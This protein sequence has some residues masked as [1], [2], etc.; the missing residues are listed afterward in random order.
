MKFAIV[1]GKDNSKAEELSKKIKDY[2]GSKDYE[3][4]DEV[5]KAEIAIV[6][7]G[8]GT[9]I[10]TACSYAE[11]G[12]PFVGINAGT[13]GFLTAEEAGDWQKV[14]DKL[15]D[16]DYVTSERMTLEAG[17]V[18]RDQ[19]SVTS[20][21]A[22]NEIVIKGMYRVVSLEIHVNGQKFL[23]SIGDGVI[24]ATPT[25]STAYSL[26]A[27]GPI[28][29]PDVD[30]ILVTP[31]NTVGL[32][33][34]CVVLSPE[35]KLEIKLVYGSDVSMVIDGQQHMEIVMG[36]SVK[37]EKGKH[38]VKLVYFDKHHFLQALNAKFGLALRQAQG[39]QAG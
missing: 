34:P 4:V 39:K 21:R 10:H 15:I 3:V 12:V 33:T 7:G 1:V 2:L 19:R 14:V 38:K 30:S 11:S 16:G 23:T 28:V 37:V 5:E 35:D 17:I 29:D 26:S 18:A 36:Q 6:L 8:D 13:L 25:G 24:L 32:P 31:I 9:L 20:H 22:V 27:G